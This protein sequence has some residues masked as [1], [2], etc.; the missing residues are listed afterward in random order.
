MDDLDGFTC[1][2]RLD[3][4]VQDIQFNQVYVSS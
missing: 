4:I 1:L 2:T 3:S